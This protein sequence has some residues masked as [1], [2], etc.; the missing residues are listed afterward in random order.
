MIC[1][2]SGHLFSGHLCLSVSIRT[3][4]RACVVV[5]ARRCYFSTTLLYTKW[6]PRPVQRVVQRFC[7][8]SRQEAPRAPREWRGY[9]R[10]KQ[11][12]S[13]SRPT[14]VEMDKFSVA[15]EGCSRRRMLPL[16][17]WPSYWGTTCALILLRKVCRQSPS[18]L[19]KHGCTCPIVNNMYFFVH[20]SCAGDPILPGKH[21][22][23]SRVHAEGPASERR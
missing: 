18:T 6:L 9:F 5:C 1:M 12:R 13:P 15:G 14:S 21:K 20:S 4:V 11:S 3:D 8:S 10:G 7:R 2:S 16:P 19:H 22:D 17:E 23:S